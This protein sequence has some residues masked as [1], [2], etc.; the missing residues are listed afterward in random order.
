MEFKV[1]QPVELIDAVAIGGHTF[2]SGTNASVIEVMPRDVWV[3]LGDFA[4]LVVPL[5]GVRSPG[6]KSRRA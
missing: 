5:S 4:T 1:G 6:G 3:R 2:P